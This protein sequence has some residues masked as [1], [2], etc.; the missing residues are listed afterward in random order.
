MQA[1]KSELSQHGGNLAHSPTVSVIIPTYNRVSRL[2]ETLCSV[3]NQT[4]QDFEL[5]VIDDGSTDDSRETLKRFR[6]NRLRYVY[7]ENRGVS[8]ARNTGIRLA[9]FSW[10]CFLDSDDYWK[11][12]KLQRQLE[13]LQNCPNY[14]VSYTDEIWIRRGK[15]VNQKKIHQKY[16]GWIYHR[17]LPL[18]IISPS[19]VLVHQAVLN[20]EGVFDEELPVCEDYELWLRIACRHPIL[21]LQD[22]LIVKV[23]GHPDQ[24]SHSMWGMD[25]YRVKALLKIASSGHLTPLQKAWTAREISRKAAILATVFGKRQK[26]DEA[27]KYGKLTEEYEHKV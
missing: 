6:D 8:S 3:F 1:K 5:I 11:P 10:L 14:R 25:R 20:Q 9:T 13:A 19:S 16:G 23:G 27:E 12:H 7:Q 17:C 18:C 26:W 4:Y 24:L 22:P 2:G 15:R 21:F